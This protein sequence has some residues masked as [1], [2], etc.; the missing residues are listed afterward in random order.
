MDG[1]LDVETF[2]DQAPDAPTFFIFL[3]HSTVMDTSYE[4]E[5]ALPASYATP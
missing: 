3:R 4:A 1:L 5:C 2:E